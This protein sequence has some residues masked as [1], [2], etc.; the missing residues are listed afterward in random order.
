[1][2]VLLDTFWAPKWGNSEEE[3]EDAF[4]PASEGVVEGAHL[5]FAVADGATEAAFSKLWA[6]LL[7]AGYLKGWISTRGHDTRDGLP[8]L[9]RI[10]RR[11]VSRKPLPWYGEHKRQQGSFAALIGLELSSS[12]NSES[13]TWRSY[14]V[15]DCCLF[16]VRGDRLLGSF[17]I[18]D[19]DEFGSRPVLLSSNADRNGVALAS[20]ATAWGDWAAGDVFHLM[21]DAL[22]CWFL[23][24]HRAGEPPWHLARA[25]G[26]SD[27]EDEF[28]DWISRLRAEH[29]LR[30]DDV[31][32][33]RIVVP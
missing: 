7:V 28:P 26:T 5:R 22:A 1:M 20:A 13:G 14:A 33:F 12:E 6:R 31:T 3:Y 32:L 16:H 29:E 2:R 15:G 17:P 30:N 27:A 24:E 9:G 19:P 25:F 4:A 10:W 18:E 11:R 8:R 23:T 21:S